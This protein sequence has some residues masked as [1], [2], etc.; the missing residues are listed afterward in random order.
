MKELDQII[1]LEDGNIQA[2]GKHQELY[3]GNKNYRDLCQ[4]FDKKQ[5]RNEAR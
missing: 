4:S 3:E 2:I 1:Y 5:T